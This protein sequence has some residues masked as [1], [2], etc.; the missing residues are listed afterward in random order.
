[1]L[2]DI[3]RKVLRIIANYTVLRRR[4]PV[5]EELCIKTGRTEKGIMIV[6]RELDRAGYIAWHPDRPDEITLIRAW[7]EGAW[8]SIKEDRRGNWYEGLTR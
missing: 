8:P 7:E 2:E 1:M 5:I 3:E 4:P 6:L